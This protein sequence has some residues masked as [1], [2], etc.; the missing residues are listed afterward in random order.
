[1]N[2]EYLGNWR[3]RQMTNASNAPLFAGCDRLDLMKPSLRYWPSQPKSWPNQSVFPR[4]LST[5]TQPSAWCQDKCPKCE[6]VKVSHSVSP[7][8]YKQ[9]VSLSH[10]FFLVHNLNAFQATEWHAS[11]K[12]KWLIRKQLT[13][14]ICW[15]AQ[16]CGTR[17]NN[18]I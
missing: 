13:L 4:L 10:Y 8:T 15:K 17:E 14:Q 5:M 11:Q 18:L 1:M 3:H 16:A 12:N 6:S 2:N 7:S 9:R